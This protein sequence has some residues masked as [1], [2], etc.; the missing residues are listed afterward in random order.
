MAK[1]LVTGA[2]G[3]IGARLVRNLV[4]RGHDVKCFIRPTASRSALK[5]LPVEIAEG[6]ITIE[7]TVYR[8][9]AGC[10]RV[11]HVAAAY[12]MW[13]TNPAKIMD[14]AIRGTREVLNAIERRGS[15][16]ERIVVTSSVA[17]IGTSPAPAPMNEDTEWNL[18][19]SELYIVAKRRAEELALSRAGRLPIVI[20]N[21]C[22]VF[23]PGDARPTPSGGLIVKYLNWKAPI[24][25]P[26]SAGG[27]SVVDVDDVCQGHIGAMEKGRVGERYILGGDN[28]TF[29]QV[30]ESMSSITGLRGPG[31]PAGKGLAEL[32][33]R[34]MELF[35]RLTGNEPEVTYKLSR[36]FYDTFMWASSAKAE[37]EL[38]YKH[39]PARKTL[40]RAIRWYLDR[41][42]VD[43]STAAEI[44][45]D[46]LP[47]PDP[48]P[49]LPHE[50]NAVYREG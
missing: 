49:S 41:G 24:G 9:L 37:T 47:G 45:Y 2:S 8:A 26:V 38:G 33:G 43:P 36:D 20:V 27:L 5:G 31:K 6:D 40:A 18:A 16:I 48:A 50:R 19:D 14:P 29:T 17:A 28:L 10:D 30:I 1:A 3:F 46:D 7:H 34:G 21:P 11:Y 13:D 44:R 15:Q 42:Y 22:G 4:E 35:A 23:G 25:F 32:V 12:K 39:R